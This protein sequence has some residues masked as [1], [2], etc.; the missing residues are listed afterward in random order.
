[1]SD[2]TP[3]KREFFCELK[4][5]RQDLIFLYTLD[6]L[7]LNVGQSLRAGKLFLV[8]IAPQ[9]TSIVGT[10]SQLLDI[11]L[12]IS[13]SVTIHNDFLFKLLN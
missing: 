5:Y 6:M 12:H 1:M 8:K 3:C 2:V 9:F 7:F 4:I 13:C 11:M 10:V